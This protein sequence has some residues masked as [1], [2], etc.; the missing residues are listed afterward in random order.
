MMQHQAPVEW[1]GRSADLTASDLCPWGHLTTF[2]YVEKIQRVGH[3]THVHFWHRPRLCIN[4]TH[5]TRSVNTS[6]CHFSLW[7]QAYRIFRITDCDLLVRFFRRVRRIAESCHWLRHKSLSFRLS[8]CPSEWNN[9]APSGR[10]FVKFDIW[11]N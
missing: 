11:L 8:V 4:R 7:F 1:Q 10:I 9:S 5:R 2:V 3:A 6:C